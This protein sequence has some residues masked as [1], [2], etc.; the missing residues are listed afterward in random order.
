MKNSPPCIVFLTLMALMVFCSKQ[1]SINSQGGGG[2]EVEVVG[3]VVFP[4]NVPAPFTQVK[5][6]PEKY[7]PALMGDVADSLI[8]T[9]DASG[10]YTFKNVQPGLYNIQAM[11]L[12]NM[13]RMLLFNVKVSGDT[14]FVQSDSLLKPGSVKLIP[15]IETAEG[16]VTIPGT[17][18]AIVI[19]GKE[20]EIFLDSVPAGKIPE[21]R[22]VTDVVITKQ[23]VLVKS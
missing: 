2:S 18:I 12:E 23:D 16:Y 13:T 17:D 4:G 15:G 11:Q 9:S 5:L 20:S 3:Q 8:D 22:Y 19:D 21:I 14:T 7:N 10:Q 6:I 1:V